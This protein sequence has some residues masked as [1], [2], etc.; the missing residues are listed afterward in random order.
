[1]ARLTNKK[2]AV[3]D[4][5]KLTGPEKAAVILLSL[6]ED[7]TRL[8]QGLDEDEIKEI[9]QA[10]ASLGTV[11]AQ[12]V[13]E[14]LVEFVSGMSGSG[15]VMGSFEQTQ[16][17][18]AS[19]MPT[20]RVE[21]LMEEI[22]GPAGRTMWD[23]LGN[24]N[25]AVLANYLKN[26]YPQ[27]VAVV[28]SKVKPDHA[29]RVLTS[30]PE[31]FALECVQRMLR[32]E[33]VQREILDKIEQTL[34]TEFMSNLARTSKR[35]SHEM[36]A[37]IFNSFDR[38]TEARFIGAL[39]ERNREAAERIRALMF[40]FEDLAKLDPGGIQTLLRAVEKD[41]LGLALKGSSESL[42]ELFFSNMSERA[43]KIMREDMESMGPVRLKDVDQAQMAMVQVAKDL[44]A[45]G[46]IM[47][48]GQGGDDELIY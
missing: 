31:D 44:A 7:H 24:V 5:R 29:A 36:M 40:V 9:S 1:M 12:V 23:K 28:L 10:M 18:L 3:E 15:A 11:S 2:P 17:L 16:R 8:W 26:E 19:F 4:A 21:G 25:E 6:G 48:V 35:D 32:M 33:P 41:S 39:E 13:E 42:R 43:A 14:L 20:D 45:K 37:D 22:R 34:R 47:L 27:T 30:L 38:Q 46:E